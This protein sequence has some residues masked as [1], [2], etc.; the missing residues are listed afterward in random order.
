MSH[1]DDPTR[2]TATQINDLIALI[3]RYTTAQT[4]FE[5]VQNSVELAFTP[6]IYRY[7][8]I[9]PVPCGHAGGWSFDRIEDDQLHLIHECFYAH[10]YDVHD[11]YRTSLTLERAIELISE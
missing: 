1:I 4:E 9:V 11:M 3:T 5:L 8:Q 2:Y 7:D 6:L 10:C